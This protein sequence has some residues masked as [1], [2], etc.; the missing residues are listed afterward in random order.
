LTGGDDDITARVSVALLEEAAYSDDQ[1]RMATL[2][3]VARAAVQRGGSEQDRFRLEEVEVVV[4]MLSSSSVDQSLCDRLGTLPGGTPV[5]EPACR[6]KVAVARQDVDE[7]IARCQRSIDARQARYGVDHPS[8]TTDL[9]NVASAY[10]VRDEH[11]QSIALLR[12]AL[13]I[14]QRSYGPR[15][16]DAGLAIVAIAVALDETGRTDE[17]LAAYDEAVA[18]LRAAKSGPT[19]ELGRALVYA[20]EASAG[21]GDVDEA[22]RRAREGIQIAERA[23]G[24]DHK[25]L[26]NLLLNHGKVLMSA[27][28]NADAVA[29][30][31]RADAIA[32]AH[33]DGKSRTRLTVTRTFAQALTQAGE[34]A[35]AIDPAKQVVDAIDDTTSPADAALARS[36]LGEALA[37]AGDRARG[38]HELLEAR[39]S[40]AG[41][42]AD[43]AKDLERIDGLLRE[44][45]PR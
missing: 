29:Q 23:L 30:L 12:R 15:S 37:R 35:A 39:R 20:A 27:A 45:P 40:L 22:D 4:R 19:F 1:Q 28:R 34:A 10:N 3:P 26:A 21:R 36:V 16:T 9:R 31:R 44:L 25:R 33:F 14:A 32:R 42:G 7:V 6:C 11:E 41:L 5:A 24:V 13:D 2:L 8:I 18:I 17:A 43:G 38:R